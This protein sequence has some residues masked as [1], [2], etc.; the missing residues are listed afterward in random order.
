M[1]RPAALAL[2]GEAADVSVGTDLALLTV[3]AASLI[4]VKV[5]SSKSKSAR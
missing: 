5:S 4:L 1:G 2:L 3:A